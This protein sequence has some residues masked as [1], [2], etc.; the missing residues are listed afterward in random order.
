LAQSKTKG[1]LMIA[2]RSDTF[3]PPGGAIFDTTQ[4]QLGFLSD[5]RFALNTA[6]GD[7]GLMSVPASAAMRSTSG[8]QLITGIYDGTQSTNSLKLRLWRNL[9]EETLTY[10]AGFV[11][12]DPL[13]TT[14]FPGGTGIYF[15]REAG[16]SGWAH[17]S[18]VV[19]FWRG[20]ALTTAQRQAYEAHLSAL[21][22]TKTTSQLVVSGDS[23][24]VGSPSHV[25]NSWVERVTA[26]LGWETAVNGS[27]VGFK[28]SQGASS[29][30]ITDRDDWHVIQPY[31]IALG[32][33]DLAV[34]HDSLATMQGNFNTLKA[35]L[36]AARYPIFAFTIPRAGANITGTDETTRAA[37]NAWLYTV[38]GITVIDIDTALGDPTGAG[39]ANF[40]GDDL[41]LSDAGHD[42]VAGLV[43]NAIESMGEMGG[44]TAIAFSHSALLSG[45]ASLTGSTP[46]T[47]TPTAVATGTGALT[48]ASAVT[49]APTGSLVGGGGLLGSSAIIITPTAAS[50]STVSLTGTA[51]ILITPTAALTGAGDRTGTCSLLMTPTGTL[52]GG[53]T[54]AGSSPLLLTPVAVPGGAGVM[55]GSAAVVIAPQG[56]LSGLGSSVL[57][58]AVAITLIPTGVM[59][60]TIPAA[61]AV[62]LTLTPTAALGGGVVASG[63]IPLTFITTGAT[64]GAGRLAGSADVDL[65]SSGTVLGSGILAGLSEINFSPAANLT[66][67][68]FAAGTAAMNF[69]TAATLIGIGNLEGVAGVTLT[70]L[71]TLLAEG[72]LAGTAA[73]VFSNIGDPTSSAD[74]DPEAQVV[75]AFVSWAVNEVSFVSRVVDTISWVSRV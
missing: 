13:P 15:G 25:G 22:F 39:D 74:F 3:S 29:P 16:G 67:F 56:A 35:K 59:L 58:G 27:T 26:L 72:A 7:Y 24:A 47:L 20:V 53:G 48:G 69:S 49:T 10:T 17:K 54:L 4:S 21:L 28:L 5:G 46:I 30:R 8:G 2:F 1:T 18:A 57:T 71:A 34:D 75:I 52:I 66:G 37:Y 50:G 42:I 45:V 14:T 33:N 11:P 41:H 31:I 60:G 63:T 9:V 43:Q 36:V 19:L 61:G 55:A 6:D 40:E 38:S 62:A 23:N 70:P 32:P 51:D 44:G 73:V 68:R 12:G 65:E 64:T